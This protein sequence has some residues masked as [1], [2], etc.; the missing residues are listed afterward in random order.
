MK[1]RTFKEELGNVK[2]DILKKIN[3]EKIY[4]YID[5]ELY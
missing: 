3:G 5:Y 1:Q 2:R 4:N